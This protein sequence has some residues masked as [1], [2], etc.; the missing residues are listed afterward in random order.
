MCFGGTLGFLMDNTIGSDTGFAVF[1]ER[2]KFQAWK[3]ALGM[4]STGA[5]MRYTLTVLLD[6]FISLIIFKPC[7]SAL[8]TCHTSD[9][10]IKH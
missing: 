2:G 4:M 7:S 3:Y 1:S 5:Y 9:V 10:G 6:L 8:Q